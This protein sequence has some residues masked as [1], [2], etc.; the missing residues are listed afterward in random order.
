MQSGVTANGHRPTATVPDVGITSNGGR[1]PAAGGRF[2]RRRDPFRIGQPRRLQQ[3]RADLPDPA[4]HAM[5]AARCD[6]RSPQEEDPFVAVP[7]RGG[8]GGDA[9]QLDRPS[10]LPAE[11]VI[12]RQHHARVVLLR[13]LQELAEDV[14]DAVEVELGDLVVAVVVRLRDFRLLRRRERREDVAD[15]VGALDVDD[16]QIGD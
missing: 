7:L 3:R 4:V 6:A 1:R 16:R 14:V 15:R 13:D 8:R 5:A 2:N 9:R 10:L 12:R 11:T